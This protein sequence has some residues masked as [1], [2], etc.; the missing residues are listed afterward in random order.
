M[1]IINPQN[2]DGIQTEE[3]P[4]VSVQSVGYL[5]GGKDTAFGNSLF[6]SYR[7]EIVINKFTIN[8]IFLILKTCQKKLFRQVTASL[9]WFLTRNCSVIAFL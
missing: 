6:P 9:A 2:S 1:G 8:N 7:R 3:N 4:C 5:F